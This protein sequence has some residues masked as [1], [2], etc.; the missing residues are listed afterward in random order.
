VE[1][2]IDKQYGYYV[3]FHN[4]NTSKS[5]KNICRCMYVCMQNNFWTW[6]TILN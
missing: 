6:N 5:A 3:I 4:L 1:N 2:G